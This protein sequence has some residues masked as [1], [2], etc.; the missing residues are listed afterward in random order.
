MC[1]WYLFF[2]FLHS[3]FSHVT[4]VLPMINF[5]NTLFFTVKSITNLGCEILKI[6]M[7]ARNC[8]QNIPNIR[9]HCYWFHVIRS[10]KEL[11]HGIM[12][13]C[14]RCPHR[15]DG[16]WT[17]L[18]SVVAFVLFLYWERGQTTRKE[19]GITKNWVKK[20]FHGKIIS[21]KNDR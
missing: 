18:K 20:L 2:S 3:C 8:S 17:I 10:D 11:N 12:E 1:K 19:C 5:S 4:Q 16:V 14:H 7:N 21:R 6:C 15:K 13:P 9:G